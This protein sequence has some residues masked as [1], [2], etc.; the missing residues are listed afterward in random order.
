MYYGLVNKDHA[1]DIVDAVVDCLG[2]GDEHKLIL[3]ETAQ[4]E[5][6]MGG[7]NDPTKY[8][9]GTGITQFDKMP[10][11]DVIRRTRPKHI[12][13]INETF[14]FDIRKVKWRELELSPLLC[15]IATRLHYKLIP[16]AIPTTI[17]GR[18]KYWKKY[19][20][21]EA[22]RGTEEEYIYNASKIYINK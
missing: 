18:A 9:A 16:E 10:F 6:H 12:K 7:F 8:S 15:F 22:G 19:Y 4:Q 5:T 2:G 11:Y 1:F 17:R 21:T 13:K 20:N 14:G 3:L